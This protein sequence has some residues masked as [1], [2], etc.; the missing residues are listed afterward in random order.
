MADG[1]YSSKQECLD[2]TKKRTGSVNPT[3]EGIEDNTRGTGEFEP[4]KEIIEKKEVKTP[5]SRGDVYTET[6]SRILRPYEIRQLNRSGR[7]ADNRIASFSAQCLDSNAVRE[8]RN[9]R[10]R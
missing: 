1:N 7:I 4:D 10:R 5:G 9:I 8:G 2:D 3:K 6:E